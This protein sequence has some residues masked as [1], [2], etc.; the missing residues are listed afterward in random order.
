MSDWLVGQLR[1]SYRSGPP[2]SLCTQTGC[3]FL[4]DNR[5]GLDPWAASQASQL[6]TL[7]L[8]R[9]VG[10]LCRLRWLM[11]QNLSWR[12]H[13]EIDRRASLLEC[14]R[15]CCVSSLMPLVIS[16]ILPLPIIHR[17]PSWD[18]HDDGYAVHPDAGTL[19]Y[20]MDRPLRLLI[21]RYLTIIYLL[22]FPVH[23]NMLGTGVTLSIPDGRNFIR[24]RDPEK[25]IA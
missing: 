1:D 20:S 8:P 12:P 4:S 14:L 7:S 11:Q 17:D 15:A 6:R 5:C 9:A 25:T 23:N 3:F 19:L 2:R 18:S 13:G 22:T 10:K 16:T 24:S 21:Y